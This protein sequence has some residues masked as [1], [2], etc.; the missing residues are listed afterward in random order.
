MIAV[1]MSGNVA[2]TVEAVKAAQERGAYV[3][4]SPIP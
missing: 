1:S 3:V 2:R 4:E